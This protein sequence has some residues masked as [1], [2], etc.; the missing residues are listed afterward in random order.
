MSTSPQPPVFV[1]S[2]FSLNDRG[3]SQGRSRNYFSGIAYT[4]DAIILGE[5]GLARYIDKYDTKTFCRSVVDGRFYAFLEM[6]DEYRAFVDPLSQDTLFY[7][8]SNSN[9]SNGESNGSW[10]VSNSLL[11]LAEFLYGKV[12]LTH[13]RPALLSFF[14]GKGSGIGAQPISSRTVFSEIRAL[15]LGKTL[16]ID[17]KSQV[18]RLEGNPDSI[19]RSF[20][21][22]S[23]E[24][25]VLSV[26][27]EGASRLRAM[28]EYGFKFTAD[29]TGGH[30]SR[31]CFGL[32]SCAFDDW[33][34]VRLVSNPRKD[35]DYRIAK[36]LVAHYG[37]KLHSNSGKSV[38]VD[39][40]HAYSTWKLGSIGTYLPVYLPLPYLSSSHEYKING[41]MILAKEFAAQKPSEF[42]ESLRSSYS[43][44]SDYQLVKNEFCCTLNEL[45][46]GSDDENA[47]DWF[48]LASRARYHY[49]R[50]WYTSLAF[51]IV[52]PLIN[53]KTFAASLR[54]SREELNNGKLSLDILMALD[55]VLALHPFDSVEKSFSSEMILQSPFWKTKRTTAPLV[56]SSQSYQIFSGSLNQQQNSEVANRAAIHDSCVSDMEKDLIFFSRE[57]A[58]VNELFSKATLDRA[59]KEIKSK[60]KLSSRSRLATHIITCGIVEKLTD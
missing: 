11:G 7:Y 23:Y 55:P 53:P 34:K 32:L 2:S 4:S 21:E 12:K 20:K 6:D 38:A 25:L 60:D 1:A 14:I 3:V 26:L 9:G 49:G 58:L 59:L 48:Y 50:S 46:V 17:K 19:T 57:S 18:L 56:S 33:N 36:S 15:P 16:I 52:S 35:E 41:G 45:E 40:K 31:A 39:P 43:H 27:T 29:L 22:A 47:M 5:E 51:P 44:D 54:L 10:A 8:F 28:R 24:E 42:L 30:D 37:G 13:Y